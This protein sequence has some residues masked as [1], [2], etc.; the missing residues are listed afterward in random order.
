MIGTPFYVMAYISGRI[1]TDAAVPEMSS[2]ERRAVFSAMNKTLAAIHSVD[3]S[4][5]G[6]K[7][8]GKPG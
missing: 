6:L 1:Y 5:E 8:Y 7:D 4:A 3:I 2:A